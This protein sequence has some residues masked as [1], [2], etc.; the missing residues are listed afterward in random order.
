MRFVRLLRTVLI[1]IIIRHD[2]ARDVQRVLGS[3]SQECQRMLQAQSVRCLLLFEDANNLLTLSTLAG[4][5]RFV[6]ANRTASS[7][8]KGL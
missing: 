4:R 2:S 1:I 8:W 3:V 7:P 6:I 5:W